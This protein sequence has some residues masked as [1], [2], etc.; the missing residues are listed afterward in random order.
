MKFFTR[1][2]FLLISVV[3]IAPA[4]YG[5]VAVNT[6]NSVPDPSAML[7]VKSVS[8]GFL[9]PRMG[10]SERLSIVAPASG[11]IVYQLDNPVGFYYYTGSAWVKLQESITETDPV[12]TAWNKS[13]GISITASQIINFNAYVAIN[14][15]VLANSAKISYPAT[16]ATKLASIEPGAQ[17]NVNSDWNATSGDAVIL[18]K[19][20]LEGLHVRMDATA[21]DLIT[22]DGSNWVAAAPLI[23]NNG[24][25]PINNMQPYLTIN[26]CISLYGIFPQRSSSD[27][28]V[29]EICLFP[30]NF[31]PYHWAMCNGQILPIS[32]NTALFALLGIQYG[33]NGATTF[34]LPDFQGQSPVNQGQGPGLSQYYM[35]DQ[36]GSETIT[37]LPSEI[38]SHTHPI[39]FQ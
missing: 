31:A 13:T 37:L 33:G 27:P 16:N 32:Q 11:L 30:F 17:V 3:L 7:D 22:Y 2:L 29:G 1:T 35:G 20:I 28:F 25:L 34:A 12:F 24:D 23:I 18:N 4:V 14:S 26:F 15:S 5:Q 39:T 9:L 38:P 10:S 21:G 6:D 36:T 8:S 19:P